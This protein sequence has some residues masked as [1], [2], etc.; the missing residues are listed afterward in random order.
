MDKE[1]VWRCEF[2]DTLELTRAPNG[3]NTTPIILVNYNIRG[4]LKHLNEFA[5][6]I[7]YQGRIQGGSHGT[8]N[9]RTLC[10]SIVPPL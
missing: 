10:L 3:W 4:Q 8:P 6:L 1:Y 7:N 9:G 5:M 2:S